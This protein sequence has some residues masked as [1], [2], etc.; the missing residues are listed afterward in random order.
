ML[1]ACQGR[2]IAR[3]LEGM[4]DQAFRMVDRPAAIDQAEHTAAMRPLAGQQGP[5][6]G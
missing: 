2:I 6:A 3:L 4:H 1:K 5:A